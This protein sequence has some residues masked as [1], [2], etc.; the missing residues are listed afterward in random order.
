M[1]REKL[2]PKYLKQLLD[3]AVRLQPLLAALV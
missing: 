3:K 1:R 2:F